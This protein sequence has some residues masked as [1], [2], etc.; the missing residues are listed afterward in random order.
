[1]KRSLGN[2]HSIQQKK[3]NKLH[4]A[5]AVSIFETN[6]ELD[7]EEIKLFCKEYQQNH[8]SSTKSNNGGY[9]SHNLSL[10]IPVLQS[11]I[12]EIEW[13]TSRGMNGKSQIV[14]NIWFNVNQY[15]DN[16]SSHFHPFSVYSGVYYVETPENCGTIQFEHPA[17]D[18]LR[19]YNRG[20]GGEFSLPAEKNKMYVFPSWLKHSVTPNQSEE[21]RISISFNT[22]NG[23]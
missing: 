21:E 18:I 6:L 20:E 10:E 7:T 17:L 12:R 22:S 8:E 23:V 4:V 1:M 15:K 13:A 2:I 11:L 9:Q 3:V 19:Y 5:F 14:F 16:N